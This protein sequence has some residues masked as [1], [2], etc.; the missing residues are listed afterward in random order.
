MTKYL[1]VVQI[2]AAGN[3]LTGHDGEPLWFR[4]VG[5]LEDG[6]LHNPNGYPDELVRTALLAAD[7]RHREQDRAEPRR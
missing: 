2:D 4:D 5:I 6:S 3:I 7:A 1:S